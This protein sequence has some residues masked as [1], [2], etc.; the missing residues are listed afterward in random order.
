MWAAQHFA[1]FGCKCFLPFSPPQ[2]PSSIF[3]YSISTSNCFIRSRNYNVFP[4][5]A[6]LP[7]FSTPSAHQIALSDPEITMFS[8]GEH[9]FHFSLLHQHIKLLYQIQKFQCFPLG[10]I[11]SIFLYSV[12]TS[13]CFIRSRN[14]NVFPGGASPETPAIIFY[15]QPNYTFS[16]QLFY[17]AYGAPER[18]RKLK[19]FEWLDCTNNK[20]LNVAIAQTIK[21][22]MA[23]LHKQ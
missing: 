15:C 3:L 11:S 6:S 2:S 23:R 12:S 16:S 19:S 7:F 20:V 18:T 17:P 9:L 21:F 8:P 5:G 13:N 4:G 10:S 22:R 14:S 1:G